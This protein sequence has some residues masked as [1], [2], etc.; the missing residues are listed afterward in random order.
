MSGEIREWLGDLTV[1]HPDAAMAVGQA[2]V[3]LADMGPD[4][5]PPVVVALH[6]QAPSADPADLDYSYQYR[7]E[8]LQTL[9]RA[10]AD[11]ST[12]RDEVQAHINELE[13]SQ[14]A[15]EIAE[16]RLLLPRLDRAAQ[17]L[18][19]ASQ[20]EQAE[21]DAFRSRKEILRARFT[22]ASANRA[23]A[24]YCAGAATG[25]GQDEVAQDFLS[26]AQADEQ[27]E[28]IT[29]QIER[30]LDRE[31]APHGL[32][33]LRA[34]APGVAVGG[35]RI[36]FA[37]EPPGTALLISV[38]ESG[39][40]DHGQHAEAVRVSGAV[41]RQVRAGEDAGAAAVTFPGMQPFIN[42]FFTT[43]AERV[44]A[45]A[46]NL[47]ARTRAGGTATKRAHSLA[48][49]RISL[50][51]A[52]TDVAG[53]MGVPQERVLAIERDSGTSEVRALA[54][55]IAALGGRLEVIADFDGEKIALG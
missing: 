41:L 22:A 45:G 15:A 26:A 8:R 6:N 24:E 5:G 31:A 3:A 48:D 27:L 9:R 17:R 19:E 21:T 18:T 11:V 49:K 14:S 34:D 55:Y 37:V 25:I 36:I 33:E 54:N 50:G 35:I 52:Q 20:R 28:D 1:T 16:L 43:S 10:V 23:L 13:E 30:E 29:A 53:R 32:M 38:I 51:L 4:L 47:I 2:V 46:A 39:P 42:E 7:L 12:L 44:R 40:A